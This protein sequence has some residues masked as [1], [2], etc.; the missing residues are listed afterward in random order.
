MA[1]VDFERRIERLFADAPAF[2]DAEAFAQRVERRLD[3][4]WATRRVLIGFAGVVGGVIGASQLVLSN[5]ATDVQAAAAGPARLLTA[6]VSQVA[7]QSD[8]MSALTGAGNVVW[9][10]AG[11]AGLAVAFVI[12]RMI[13][14]I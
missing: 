4:G 9:L 5:F 10:A 3:R 12:T 13:E 14:E 6:G 11:L 2:G 8:W 7:S 1:E